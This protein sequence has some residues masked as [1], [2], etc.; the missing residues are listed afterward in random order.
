MAVRI[1]ETRRYG[2][3]P[4][5]YDFRVGTLQIQNI[6]VAPYGDYMSATYR[7]CGCRRD[8]GIHSQQIGAFYDQVRW[9]GRVSNVCR[10]IAFNNTYRRDSRRG[11]KKAPSSYF[12]HHQFPVKNHWLLSIKSSLSL[13]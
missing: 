10:R 9:T 1:D 12:A 11:T 4:T 6:V 5:I 3:A 13:F 8:T 7:K 2:M